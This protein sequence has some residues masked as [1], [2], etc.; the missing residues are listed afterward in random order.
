MNIPTLIRDPKQT[1]AIYCDGSSLPNPGLSG[2]GIVV[3]DIIEIA[4]YLGKGSN[5]TAELQAMRDALLLSRTGDSIFSDSQYA[6]C[7]TLG[8]WKPHVS[9]VWKPHVYQNFVKE[10]RKLRPSGVRV[11]WIKGHAG[12]IW[13][14]R[15]DYLAKQAIIKR[16]SFEN[17][18]PVSADGAL[19]GNRPEGNCAPITVSSEVG[20][21]L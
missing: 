1:V 3:P 12:N 6:V 11:I 7:L 14:E 2:I 18:F 4:K 13:Q 19:T 5:Q 10:L 21:E 20:E 16:M 15:A 8:V 9:T 17:V